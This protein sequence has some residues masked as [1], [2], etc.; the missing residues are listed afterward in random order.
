MSI[1]IIIDKLSGH[2]QEGLVGKLYV[3]AG[4]EV[5]EG[6]LMFT[7]ESG[8][9]SLKYN[10]K[11]TGTINTL[12]I[13]EGDTIKK[14]QVVGHAHGEEGCGNNSVAPKKKGYSFGIN[15]PAKEDIHCDVVIV[16]GGPGGY[17]AAIR[18]AQL[19]QKVVLV[20]KDQLGGTCLNYGC[21][22]TKL[23]FT[24]LLFL[25]ALRRPSI[26]ALV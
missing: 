6:D 8:K 4:D 5:K 10:A 19:G 26:L 1:K 12:D 2:D 18:S 20:E 16:G 13:D 11:F 9:G 15:T 3:K 7:I 23:W 21:I 17:V 14:N 24:V 22:P 25:K